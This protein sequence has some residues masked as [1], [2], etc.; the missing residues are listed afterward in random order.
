MDAVTGHRRV[1]DEFDLQ[2]SRRD[3]QRFFASRNEKPSKAA[4]YSITGTPILRKT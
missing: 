1:A 3:R 2:R 4:A